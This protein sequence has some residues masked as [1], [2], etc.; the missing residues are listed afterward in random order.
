MKLYSTAQYSSTAVVL[1]STGSTVSMVRNVNLLQISQINDGN[2]GNSCSH[3][4][5][6]NTTVFSLLS[7]GTPSASR[8]LKLF[9]RKYKQHSNTHA[10]TGCILQHD[11]QAR[12]WVD[13]FCR[14][15]VGRFAACY[16]CS[17][18]AWRT[19]ACLLESNHER[20]LGNTQ[21]CVPLCWSCGFTVVVVEVG[22]IYYY[23]GGPY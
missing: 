15:R 22:A 6:T 23:Y 20:V 18:T 16:Y 4:S 11:Y 17:S 9:A 12:R 13:G 21:L 3:S 8:I 7:L 19:G 10:S 2:C 1:K 14:R 5:T